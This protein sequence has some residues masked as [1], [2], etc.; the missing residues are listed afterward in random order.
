MEPQGNRSL[1]G[2]RTYQEFK[3]ATDREVYNQAEGFVRL[4]YLLR[5]AEDTEIL[6]ESGYKSVVEF[7]RAEYGLTET[8]VSRYININKR[9][10]E[11]GYSDRLMERFQGFGLAKLADML[12]LPDEVVEALPV[13]ATRAQIQEVKR[14][15]AQER[16]VSDLE[17]LMEPLGGEEDILTKTLREY[18][19]DPDKIGEYQAVHAALG[20]PGEEARAKRLYDA[21]A[22]AGNAVKMARVPGTGRVMVTIRGSD[23]KIELLNIRGGERG[24]YDWKELY[25]RLAAL[26]PGGEAES[27]EAVYGE[28]FPQGR[29]EAG[30]KAA[31]VSIA[32]AAVAPVQEAE[33]K[34]E[35][36]ESPKIPGKPTGEAKPKEQEI[37]PV[38]KE[39]EENEAEPGAEEPSVGN[40][41][42]EAAESAKEKREPESRERQT[43]KRKEEDASRQQAVGKLKEE[44]LERTE[45]IRTALE[46][47][48]YSMARSNAKKLFG[49]LEAII[50]ELD[51]K[52][53]PG[54]MEIEELIGKETGDDE[55][56]HMGDA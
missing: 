20:E 24:Y 39:R 26:F 23:Q 13:E 34:E 35:A 45:A 49:L 22:P 36:P 31:V 27:W 42:E 50:R 2:I 51:R 18:Y 12:T 19:R 40:G 4:G 44:A 54:Q 43:E 1:E 28:E 56:D 15:V 11:G 37:A 29:Q 53:V 48:Y 8:Y 21:M 5:R 14:E 46:K 47:G 25:E 9:Y 10:S 38:Q 16:Q 41:A 17:I 6:A 32:K 52:G 7:A 55:E 3:A 33:P 30:K